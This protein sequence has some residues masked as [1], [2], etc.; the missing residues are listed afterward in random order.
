MLLINILNDVVK[1]K[2]LHHPN[3]MRMIKHVRKNKKKLV[4]WKM[5]R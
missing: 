2:Q 4:R 3:T 1:G 5:K